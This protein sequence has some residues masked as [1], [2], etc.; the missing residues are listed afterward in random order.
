MHIHN[1][2]AIHHS[3]IV[4]RVVSH[5]IAVQQAS[6]QWLKAAAI[7]L[8][9][10]DR[11]IIE[12]EADFRMAIGLVST[13][14]T[15]FLSAERH[16]HILE[17][18]QVSSQIH[19]DVAANRIAEALSDVRLKRK[20]QRRQ[21]VWEV[22]GFVK[23][24]QMHLLVAIKLVPAVRSEKRADELWIRTAHPVGSKRLRKWKATEE[25]VEM[26]SQNEDA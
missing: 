14:A 11:E 22:I 3:T 4:Y 17:R 9:L 24:A 1:H 8:S 21:D 12:L 6:R 10:Q 2:T 18:R 25:F 26:G 23:S 5:Q 13:A 15:V 16:R 7:L 20:V 19:A